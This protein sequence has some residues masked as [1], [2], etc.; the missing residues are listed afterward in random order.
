MCMNTV[1]MLAILYDYRFKYMVETFV[2]PVGVWP[3]LKSS[4]ITLGLF[5][6]VCFKRI[7]TFVLYLLFDL[8]MRTGSFS[9]EN[10]K[11]IFHESV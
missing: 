7:I 1:G 11:N 4:C 8:I 5:F 3:V 10:K 9:Q 2:R 6:V